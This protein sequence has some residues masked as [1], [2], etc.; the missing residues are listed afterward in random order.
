MNKLDKLD[1]LIERIDKAYK[2][3][4]NFLNEYKVVINNDDYIFYKCSNRPTSISIITFK[5]YKNNNEIIVYLDKDSNKIIFSSDVN[6][7]DINFKK[8]EKIC[9]YVN[10]I[11]DFKVSFIN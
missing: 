5:N 11:L 3:I 7:D 1:E 2:D 9:K 10:K 4:Y 6:I 8:V